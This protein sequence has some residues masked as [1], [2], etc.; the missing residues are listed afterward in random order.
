MT[1]PNIPEP[2]PTSDRYDDIHSRGSSFGQGLTEDSIRSM[3]MGQSATPFHDA[4]ASFGAL[5]KGIGDIIGGAVE[6]GIGALQWIAQGISSLV[7]G[8]SQA[9]RGV[10]TPTVFAPIT[11]AITDSQAALVDRLDLIPPYCSVVMSHN[12]QMSWTGNTLK[13]PF[14][15]QNGPA[16][17]AHLDVD[18][19]GIV[20]DTAG[21]W[22]VHALLNGNGSD[23]A[24]SDELQ[25]FL[26]L[27]DQNHQLQSEKIIRS[28]PGTK[29]QGL[30]MSQPFVIPEPGWY[31]TV[32]GRSGR[33]R[34]WPGGARWS[35]L[36]VVYSHDQDTAAAPDEV[37]DTINL[38]QP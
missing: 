22:T 24:G 17:G 18:K 4:F 11:E 21:T 12:V 30:S 1:S 37:S 23:G 14:R 7:N 26:R 6:L 8:I 15:T 27:Y 13:M 3:L 28:S 35:G 9:I 25:M 5:L 20:F 16:K 29:E 19:S 34:W 31:I 33:P 32:W 2:S 10:I 36:T 38:D